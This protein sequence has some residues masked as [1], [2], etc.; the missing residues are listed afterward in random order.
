MD[1]IEWRVLPYLSSCFIRRRMENSCFGRSET[2][3]YIH[4]RTDLLYSVSWY[5]CLHKTAPID[6]GLSTRVQRFLSPKPT[7]IR[8]AGRGELANLTCHCSRINLATYWGSLQHRGT[9]TLPDDLKNVNLW[10][11]QP[12]AILRPF[13]FLHYSTSQCVWSFLIKRALFTVISTHNSWSNT[14]ERIGISAAMTTYIPAQQELITRQ[15]P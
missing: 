11:F 15:N 7:C 12:S 4:W 3:F 6:T 8:L 2:Q 1:S 13:S 14:Q 9:Q 5:K 10:T